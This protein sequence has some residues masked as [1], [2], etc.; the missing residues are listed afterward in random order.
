VSGT[1]TADGEL[2]IAIEAAF[3][4][5]PIDRGVIVQ[6]ECH[7]ATTG[8]RFEARSERPKLKNLTLP[9]TVETSNT[10]G[11]SA[12]HV[13]THEPKV[14]GKAGSAEFEFAVGSESWHHS[15]TSSTTFAGNEC[16]LA[17]VESAGTYIRWHLR[18]DRAGKAVVDYVEGDLH[19]KAKAT[20]SEIPGPTVTITAR[21]TDIRFFGSRGEVLPRRSSIG[22]WAKLL[23]TGRPVPSRKATQHMVRVIDDSTGDAWAQIPLR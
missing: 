22:L 17:I 1:L 10:I 19:L 18:R 8:A 9:D 12:E 2:R 23:L 11:E 14:K 13:T 5:V 7:V 4:P 6:Y 20:S 3:L 21:P 15:R 16:R